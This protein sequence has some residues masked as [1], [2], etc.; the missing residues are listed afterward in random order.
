MREIISPEETFPATDFRAAATPSSSPMA[1]SALQ[2][3]RDAIAR[4]SGSA[5]PASARGD[6]W[7]VSPQA[8]WLAKAQQDLTAWIECGGFT[9]MGDPATPSLLS[10][11]CGTAVRNITA[12][13]ISERTNTQC[14]CG[15][16]FQSF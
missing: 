8:R 1:Q 3:T 11:P 2:M 9:Q 15:L 14:L 13:K 7:R 16:T 5:S 4:Q 12:S 6:L 10:P